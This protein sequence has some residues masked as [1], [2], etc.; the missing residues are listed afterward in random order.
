MESKSTPTG[1]GQPVR[2]FIR[3]LAAIIGSVSL[4]GLVLH[5]VLTYLG[6]PGYKLDV[7]AAP[8]LF[9]LALFAVYGICM[10]VRG[11]A[12]MG[13]LPWK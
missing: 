13:V 6:A 3:A 12:P 5:A 7:S 9:L 2:P 4:I 10:G 8:E 1:F 11:K